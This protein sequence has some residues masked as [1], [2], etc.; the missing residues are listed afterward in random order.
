MRIC[1]GHGAWDGAEYGDGLDTATLD[2]NSV[3]DTMKLDGETATASKGWGLGQPASG[4]KGREGGTEGGR[5]GATSLKK[6]RQ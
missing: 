5:E 6:K 3:A 2:A 4:P 1:C